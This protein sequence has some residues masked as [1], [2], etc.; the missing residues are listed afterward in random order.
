MVV[1]AGEGALGCGV[2]SIDRVSGEKG[3]PIAVCE[4]DFTRSRSILV[5]VQFRL[6]R[7]SHIRETSGFFF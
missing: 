3:S 1:G 4:A 5:Y 7:L 2:G 6:F